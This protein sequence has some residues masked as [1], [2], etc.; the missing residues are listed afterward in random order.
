MSIELTETHKIKL[1]YLK[2]RMEESLRKQEYNLTLSDALQ[3]INGLLEHNYYPFPNRFHP[4]LFIAVC[5]K[6]LDILAETI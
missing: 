1:R 3:D 2:A 6:T 5:H 4:D